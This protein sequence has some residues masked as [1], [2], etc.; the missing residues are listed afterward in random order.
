MR[1]YRLI[2]AP[3]QVQ[4]YKRVPIKKKLTVRWAFSLW[5]SNR[6]II[7]CVVSNDME[8][9]RRFSFRLSAMILSALISA[10]YV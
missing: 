8:T 3:A 1:L 4:V 7:Q 9:D 6:P 10:L 2:K 5:V